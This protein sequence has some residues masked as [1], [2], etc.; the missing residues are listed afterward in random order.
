MLDYLA[1]GDYCYSCQKLK[2]RILLLEAGVDSKESQARFNRV[3]DNVW[4]EFKTLQ[5][6]F[7]RE[8]PDLSEA[9]RLTVCLVFQQAAMRTILEELEEKIRKASD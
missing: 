2:A 3:L 1:S 8:R 4:D 9:Q 5:A 7:D 6:R